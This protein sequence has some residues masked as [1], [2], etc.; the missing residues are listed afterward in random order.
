M[1]LVEDGLVETRGGGVKVDIV[2]DAGAGLVGGGG[3]F[4]LHHWRLGLGAG[5]GDGEGCGYAGNGAAADGVVIH[6]DLPG[7][8]LKL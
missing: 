7:A 2:M 6:V 3:G 8:G 5:E 1:L 4:L